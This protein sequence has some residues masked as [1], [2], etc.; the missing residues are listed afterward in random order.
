MSQE[1]WDTGSSPSLAQWVKDLVWLQ[2]RR[3]WQLQLG[4]D[5]GSIC[6]QEKKKKSKRNRLF[7]TQLFPANLGDLESGP[8]FWKIQEESRVFPVMRKSHK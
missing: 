8:R 1:H 3:R 6:S 2:L 4:S 5:P 7:L